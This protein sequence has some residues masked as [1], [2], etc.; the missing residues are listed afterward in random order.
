MLQD[1]VHFKRRVYI[2]HGVKCIRSDVSEVRFMT[3]QC[4]LVTK[5]MPDNIS[6]VS[7][8]IIIVII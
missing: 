1:S 5:T 6:P 7:C 8:F 3:I 4:T 2:Q